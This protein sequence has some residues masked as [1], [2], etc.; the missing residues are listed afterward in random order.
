M[1]PTFLYDVVSFCFVMYVHKCCF[2]LYDVNLQMLFSFYRM[3]TASGSGGDSPQRPD[4]QGPPQEP[5]SQGPKKSRG[6]TTGS[7]S[8][9]ATQGVPGAKVVKW[10]PINQTFYQ[11]IRK[12][13]KKVGLFNNR[14]GALVKAHIPPT[15]RDWSEVTPQMLAA[16]LSALH[17]EFRFVYTDPD[18][19]EDLP[20]DCYQNTIDQAIIRNAK[21]RRRNQKSKLSEKFRLEFCGSTE[22][23][24]AETPPGYKKEDWEAV[25][26][27]FATDDW[28]V[29]NV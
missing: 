1:S 13:N 2:I 10:D 3:S 27:E 29:R 15:T 6:P 25:V 8:A 18:T 28:K 7:T 14:L 23:A 24:K 5:D 4:S 11:E 9:R 16:I 22:N 12:E 26:D 17:S 21:I 20:A 19:G